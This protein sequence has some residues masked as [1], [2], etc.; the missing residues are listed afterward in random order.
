MAEQTTTVTVTLFKGQ[1]DEDQ[2]DLVL[3]ENWT[4]DDAITAKDISGGMVPDEVAMGM[5][6]GDPHAWLAILRV[7]YRYTSREF[8]AKRIMGQNLGSL[9]RELGEAMREAMQ[10]VPPTSASG[11]EPAE[12]S[13]TSETGETDTHAQE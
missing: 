2:I 10:G 13:E 8:P 7:S 9:T 5:M 1:P 6:N 4:F 11:N 3:P 12:R